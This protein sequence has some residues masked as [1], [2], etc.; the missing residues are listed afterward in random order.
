MASEFPLL[1]RSQQQAVLLP[2][3]SRS[4][5]IAGAGSGK[6]TVLT[7]R[8]ALVR[9]NAI[10]RTG[11]VLCLSYTN[12]AADEIGKR[13]L[14]LLSTERAIRAFAPLE[15][16]HPGIR[17]RFWNGT[18]HSFAKRVIEEITQH[19][20]W[21]S[22]PPADRQRLAGVSSLYEACAYG[23]GRVSNI[24]DESQASA[25]WNR[26]TATLLPKT[27]VKRYD[28][29]RRRE[30][31]CSVWSSRQASQMIGYLPPAPLAIETYQQAVMH[32]WDHFDITQAEQAAGM[33]YQLE[34]QRQGVCDYD[35]L[36]CMAAAALIYLPHLK[37]YYR[38]NL[39]HVLVDEAQD[40]SF[41]DYVFLMSL[42]GFLH[43]GDDTVGYTLVG[44]PRQEIFDF[45]AGQPSLFSTLLQNNWANDVQYL[46][47]NYRSDNRIIAL[48][49]CVAQNPMLNMDYEPT[50][51]S[52]SRPRRGAGEGEVHW[53]SGMN[54]DRLESHIRRAVQHSMTQAYTSRVVLIRHKKNKPLVSSILHS[55]PGAHDAFEVST[56]HSAKGG[57]W[58]H[59]ILTGLGRGQ[60]PSVP[61]FWRTAADN[62][63]SESRVLYVGITRA[64]HR[65]D[66]FE[67][68]DGTFYP[69]IFRQGKLF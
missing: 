15:E 56:F 9:K 34:K 49:G 69:S 1:D 3:E 36:L 7:V 63:R 50:D 30:D 21:W 54:K 27:D 28:W 17:Q 68:E 47:V 53:P 61:R 31:I 2:A 29:P 13:L 35:D 33:A 48:A 23:D 18:L 24:L 25:L 57:E 39:T 14:K 51:E 43:N 16:E 58:D 66:I 10:N 32:R 59:V 19:S 5:L 65:V 12:K 37:E 44:D 26:V 67:T 4:A 62:I 45:R 42:P 52:A 40:I 6:T 22:L 38:K 46:A 11:T 60:F 64:K 20:V 55:I 8:A 41:L